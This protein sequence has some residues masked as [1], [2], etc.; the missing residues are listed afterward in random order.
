MKSREII[1]I[2]FFPMSGE[3][4]IKHKILYCN[5]GMDIFNKNL[6][7]LGRGKKQQEFQGLIKGTM[8]IDNTH[9]NR[10]YSLFRV[11]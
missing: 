6:W 5:N 11:H 8:P 2:L 10:K 7:F 4:N 9:E 1:N 3:A